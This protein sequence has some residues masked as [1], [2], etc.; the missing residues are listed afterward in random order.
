MK[1]LIFAALIAGTS[2]ANAQVPPQKWTQNYAPTLADWKAALLYNGN[3]I[4]QALPLKVDVTGGTS[5][6]Q[7]VNTPAITG[8]TSTNQ[9]VNAPTITGGTSTN[10]TVNTPAITGGTS[11]NQTINAPT[12]SAGTAVGLEVSSALGKVSGA[13]VSRHLSEKLLDVVSVRDFGAKGDG[14][15]DDTAAINA[16]IAYAKSTSYSGGKIF[17][18]DGIYLI[19]STINLTGSGFSLV[20]QSVRGATI[21]AGFTNANIIQIGNQ[22]GNDD[23]E[24]DGIYNLHITSQNKMTDG[25]AIWAEGVAH[26]V[27]DNVR[28]DGSLNGGI[29]IENP[30]GTTFG[31]FLSHLWIAGIQNRGLTIGAQ[32]S[33]HST[34]VTD[35]FLSDSVILPGQSAAD[36][37]IC[38]FGAGGFYASGVDIT[39]QSAYHFNNAIK[40]D[41]AGNTDVNTVMLSRVLA[42]S[43]NNEN[44]LFSGVGPIADVTIT[45]GWANTSLNGSGISFENSQTDGVTIAATTVD[46]NAQYGIVLDKGANVAITDSRILNNSMSG[47]GNYDGIAVGA[48]VSAFSITNNQIG[49]GG[50]FN[51]SGHS[52]VHQRWG[53]NISASAGAGFIVSNNR[54]FNNTRGFVNDQTTT[55]NKS[56]IGN[57]NG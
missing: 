15:T 48:G 23:N 50:W 57:V 18:P 56:I 8:G 20:G 40:M 55:T 45:N 6:N 32:S 7:T 46:S 43:S 29:D 3:T 10:Q 42:D 2:C 37:G 16:A 5:T 13:S 22:N 28:M 39:S 36:C 27:I 26:L 25:Y 30:V 54:G 49:N 52:D 21:L 14:K 41:P 19:S 47:S 38:L 51:V 4:S 11:T 1:R 9:T 34:V 44:I 17:F 12:I 31:I 33:S 24:K 53:V 35:V